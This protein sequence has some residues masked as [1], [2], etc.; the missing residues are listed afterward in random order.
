[1]LPHS[2]RISVRPDYVVNHRS[3]RR[4]TCARC[5]KVRATT[6]S[7]IA[8]Q[9]SIETTKRA[10]SMPCPSLHEHSPREDSASNGQSARSKQRSV[11][12][13]HSAALQQHPCSSTS[14]QQTFHQKQSDH[15]NMFGVDI[16]PETQMP[17]KAET[18]TAIQCA[19]I[20]Q[21]NTNSK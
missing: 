1:M 17:T 13:R 4:R 12:L 11:R 9:L 16:R 5:S 8:V 21:T 18:A 15:R 7:D 20:T 6:A 14:A 19:F 3:L 10:V 2:R